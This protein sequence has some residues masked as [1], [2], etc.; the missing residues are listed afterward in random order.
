MHCFSRQSWSFRCRPRVDQGR[1]KA[2]SREWFVANYAFSQLLLL[3]MTGIYIHHILTSDIT[4]KEKAWISNCG[5]KTMPAL[6]IAGLLGGTAFVGTGED[7]SADGA[8]YTTEDGA[9]DSGFH[10]GEKDGFSAWAQLV[11]YNKNDVAVY[12]TYDLEWVPGKLGDD[13]KTATLTATCGGSPMIKL[14]NAGPTTTNSTAFTFL[15]DGQLLGGR[16][17]M[18]DGQTPQSIS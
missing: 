5:S 18:H 9:R 10:I 7:S 12:V 2:D 14:S 6:N 15:Q 8:V 3:T 13:V 17:H 4:K 16:G 1:K 11:N